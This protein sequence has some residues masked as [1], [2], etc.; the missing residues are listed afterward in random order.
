M[1]A[2]ACTAG[3]EARNGKR[4]VVRI[5]GGPQMA[6]GVCPKSI[7][8]ERRFVCS[9]VRLGEPKSIGSL[10]GCLRQSQTGSTPTGVASEVLQKHK[11]KCGM[12]EAERKR[13]GVCGRSAEDKGAERKAKKSEGRHRRGSEGG[14]SQRDKAGSRGG[15][16]GC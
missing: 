12:G 5:P 14:G 13:I 11:A 16:C 15:G 4:G 6:D 3:S 2:V 1:G 9:K 10:L 8:G 7:R